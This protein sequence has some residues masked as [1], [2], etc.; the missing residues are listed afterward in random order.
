MENEK[1]I[2]R[3]IGILLATGIVVICV[4]E[5]HLNKIKEPKIIED[6]QNIAE[7]EELKKGRDRFIPQSMSEMEFDKTIKLSS[8]VL[9]EECFIEDATMVRQMVDL[10]NKLSANDLTK[11]PYAGK[12]IEGGTF[13]INLYDSEKNY[14]SWFYMQESQK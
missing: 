3:A 4:K 2:L 14:M 10:L 5:F 7:D 1:N 8:W 13:T 6:S 12:A 9:G 11:N